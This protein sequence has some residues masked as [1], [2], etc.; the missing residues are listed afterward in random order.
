MRNY[1]VIIGKELHNLFVSPVAYVVMG[2]FFALSGYVFYMILASVIEFTMQ[3][4]FQSQ[5]F[6][7]SPP[8]FDATAVSLRSFFGAISTFLLFLVPMMTMGVF[9]E[10]KKRGTIELLFTSPVTHLQLILGKFTAL[11]L[12][13]LVMLVPTILNSLLLYYLSEPTPPL[14][15]MLVGY[16]GAFLLGG[17][18]LAVG[19]FVSSLT[20]NQIIAAVITFGI[21]F[22]LWLIDASAG[23]GTTLIN[24]TMRYLSILNHYQDFTIGILDSQHLVFYLSLIFLGLFLTSVS[25]GSSKWRQ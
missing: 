19:L 4:A 1:L 13:L 25:L 15:P 17:T 24:E 16:L 20:E 7:T 14:A 12:L 5:Q 8:A 3:Q 9:A 18:L 23:T 2:V 11:V 10:E 22:V 21:F 6:G